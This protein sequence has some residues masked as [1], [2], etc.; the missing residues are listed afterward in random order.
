MK[1]DQHSN[2]FIGLGFAIFLITVIAFIIALTG[3]KSGEVAGALATLIAGILAL[4]AGVLVYLT[5]MSSRRDAQERERDAER[6]RKLNLFLKAEHMAYIL[7]QVNQLN[8]KATRLMFS[9]VN[10]DGHPVHGHVSAIELRIP[11]PRQLDEIWED[12]SDCDPNAVH[13]ILSIT[14]NF[15]SAEEYLKRT[16]DVPDSNQSP[17]VIYYSSIVESARLLREAMLD[18][19]LIKRHCAETPNRDRILYGDP[20]DWDSEVS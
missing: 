20:H 17:L 1:L 7:I 6:R 10:P 14:R 15:D 19:E 13:E 8:S 18:T 11:R 12:L 3:S 9:P 16:T 2:L 5:A 4:I